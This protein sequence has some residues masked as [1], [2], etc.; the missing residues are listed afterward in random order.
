MGPVPAQGIIIQGTETGGGRGVGSAGRP[1]LVSLQSDSRRALHSPPEEPAA[2]HSG[3]H[4]REGAPR[5]GL[6]VVRF[7]RAS[8]APSQR[9]APASASAS[10]PGHGPGPAAGRLG[11]RVAGAHVTCCAGHRLR[12]AQAPPL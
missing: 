3:T 11:L 12:R 10:A 5:R 1:D 6:G 9:A 8:R 2:L 4:S 7:P